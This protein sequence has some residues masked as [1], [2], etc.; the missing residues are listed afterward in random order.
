[1][2]SQEKESVLLSN[3]KTLIEMILGPRA[4][5]PEVKMSHESDNHDVILIVFAPEQEYICGRLIGIKGFNIYLIRNIID[6]VASRLR[7][8]QVRVDIVDP[9]GRRARPRQEIPQGETCTKISDD[10]KT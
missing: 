10:G 5:Y 3:V 4:V 6:I 9:S 8:P 7:V 2:M 1:M